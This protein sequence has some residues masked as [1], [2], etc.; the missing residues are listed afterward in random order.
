MITFDVSRE[1]VGRIELVV[2][3]AQLIAHRVGF[4]RDRLGLM[5]DVTA[6]HANGCPL[7]LAEM[8]EAPDLDFWHDIIGIVN[9]LDR[10][11]G[12]LT[13]CFVPRFAVGEAR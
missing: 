1:D 9:H 8:L 2:A 11:T 6:C 3:R 4:K 10:E 12:K 7:R 5:M 13:D